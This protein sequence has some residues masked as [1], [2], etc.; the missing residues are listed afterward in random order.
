MNYYE[1]LGVKQNA[2]LAAIRSAYRRLVRRYHPD[3]RPQ[4]NSQQFLDVQR[5]YETL[6]DAALRA[7]YDRSLNRQIPVRITRTRWRRPEP[8]PLIPPWPSNVPPNRFSYDLSWADDPFEE[9]FHLV[10]RIFGGI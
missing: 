4:G 6:S 8:E 3:L 5:A 1:I 10:I 2:D 7:S 9:I